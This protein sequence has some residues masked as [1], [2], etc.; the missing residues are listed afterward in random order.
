MQSKITPTHLWIIDG[1]SLLILLGV[2][3]FVS[4][5]NTP[6][7]AIVKTKAALQRPYLTVADVRMNYEALN[8]KQVRVRG[9]P[10]FLIMQ[11]LMGC[12]PD[13][14]CNQAWGQLLL[15]DERITSENSDRL[16][17][18]EIEVAIDCVGDECLITCSP[19][20]P[21]GVSIY[22]LVATVRVE[23]YGE[24]MHITLEDI[25]FDHSRQLSN[26]MWRYIPKGKFELDLRTPTPTP[27]GYS[28]Y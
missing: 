18:G 5:P 1:I 13:T 26:E 8:G 27:E 12:P 20:N 2:I 22:E 25:D 24:T 6:D 9:R 10:T 7:Q 11:T 19:L 28:L 4:V 16:H 3:I 14:C 21:L 17:G 15:T 23:D